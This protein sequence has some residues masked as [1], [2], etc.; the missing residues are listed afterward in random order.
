MAI[1][2][3]SVDGTVSTFV[4]DGLPMV[5][6][7]VPEDIP[8]FALVLFSNEHF[9]PEGSSDF[10]GPASFDIVVRSGDFTIVRPL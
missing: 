10:A 9:A 5:R 6:E 4:E 3:F 8:Y 7:R 2:F 1:T